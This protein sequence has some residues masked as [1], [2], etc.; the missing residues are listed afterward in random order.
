MDQ[1]VN[2]MH[3]ARAG[4]RARWFALAWSACVVVSALPSDAAPPAGSPIDNVARADGRDP[5]SG[6]ALWADSNPVR[7]VVQPLEALL[8]DPGRT[9]RL[10]AGATARM[11]HRLLNFSNA[12]IEVRLLLDNRTGDDFDLSGL[13]LIHDRDRDG[14]ATAADAAIPA[15]GTVVLA[16][17]DSA[18]LLIEATLPPVAT[19]GARGLLSLTAATLLQGATA[20]GLDTVVVLPAD[21][22]TAVLFTEMS[23]S[24]SS[25][26]IGDAV[27]YTVRV[28]NTSDST[29]AAVVLVEQ[30]SR[31]ISY[32]P[33]TARR[34]DGTALP[35]PRGGRGP[36]LEFDLGSLGP[37][38]LATVRLRA[39]VSPGARDG[40]GI[41]RA[42]ATGIRVTSNVATA[43][44]SLEPGVFA[45]E[46]A[47]MG[48][49]FVDRDGDRRRGAG[50]VGM[51]GIRVVV[52]DG[53][54]AVTDDEGRYS[55]Y[56]LSPRTHGLRPDPATFPEHVRQVGSDHRHG[57]GSTVRFVDVQ[58]GDLQRADFVLA[59]TPEPGSSPR[60]SVAADSTVRM[61]AQA[62][63]RTWSGAPDELDRSLRRELAAQAAAQVEGDPRA[64][65]TTGVSEGGSLLAGLEGGGYAS[66]G[67]RA[68]STKDE[69]A[70]SAAPPA[71]GPTGPSAP[72]LPLERRLDGL[73]ASV[74]FVDWADGDTASTRQVRVVAKGVAGVQFELSVDGAPVAASRVG[75]RV[76]LHD[77]G[78]EAVEYVGV[79]LA[80]GVNRLTIAQRDRLG[81]ERGRVA[82]EVVAPDRL[83][84]LTLSAP[85]SAPTGG[86]GE[87]AVMVRAT[88]ARGVP[89]PERVFVTLETSHGHWRADDLDPTAAGMQVA[90]EGG[91][92]T[93]SL[94]A[95]S[96]PGTARLVATASTPEGTLRAERSL[97]FLPGLR[98]LLMVGTIEGTMLLRNVG[99]GP[100]FA[101]AT[102]GF[103]QSTSTL[104]AR[105]DAA[106][107]AH[108]ALFVKGRVREDVM[109]TVGF[110]SDR[111]SDTRRFRDIQPDAYYPV[112]GD[113]AV[114][115]YEAQSSGRLYA[116]VDRLGASLLY[117]DFV[118]AGAGG[119]RTLSAYSRSLTGVQQ[120]Y[121]SARWRLESFGSN[122]R[123]RRRL[124]ELPGRGV[125]GPYQ[126]T[127][128][129]IVENSEVVERIVRDRNQP[130]VV[131]GVEALTRFTDY[132]LEPLTGRLLFTAPVPSFDSELNPVSLRVSYDTED[133]GASY[134]VSGAEGR[135]K[136]DERIELGGSLV[137]DRDPARPWNLRSAFAAARLGAG[138][139]LEA[140]FARSEAEGESPGDGGRIELRHDG[141]RS[142]GRLFAAL[143]DSSFDNPGA[144]FG[145]GRGEAGARWSV[146]V[147]ERTRA[148]AEGTFTA[149]AEGRERRG[150]M[151]LALDQGITSSLRG[152][153]GVR[154]SG[155]T[156][157]TG[158]DERTSLALRTKLLAQW[159][160]RPELTGYTEFEQDAREDSRRLLA[161]GGEY[162]FSGR[163]RFY[164]RHELLSSLSNVYALR[165]GE[166]RLATVLGF[167]ADVARDAHA[168]SEYRL[169][170]ALAGR[171]AEAAVGLRNTW[172]FDEWRVNTSF[173]RVS[174]LLGSNAGP[175]TAVTG[176]IETTPDPGTRASARVELRTSRANDSFLSTLG[177]ATRMNEAWTL[178][179]RTVTTLDN[180]RS[181]GVQ[182]RVRLQ[183]GAAYRDP[184]RDRWDGL[185]R[186]ELHVD[187]ESETPDARRRRLA[188]V[189]SVH[190]TGRTFELVRTTLSWAGK[191]ARERADG[192]TTTSDAQRLQLRLSRDVAKH[193]DVG[194]QT[195]ALWSD[196]FRTRRDGLGGEVGRMLQRDVWLSAG[197]NRF[198]YTDAD[199]PAD[200]WTE[201]GVY[202]RL[203]AK[204]DESVFGRL[205]SA[206]P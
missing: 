77:R 69:R 189:V 167:D 180:Q 165:A 42:W 108:A 48:V 113:A 149:E 146:R 51:P 190:A 63:G 197:W 65:P 153:F 174:P 145:A 8:V 92:A 80:P 147:N 89:V 10:A 94:G 19:A 137:D 86:A 100:V 206:L 44:V 120:R 173:E 75:R 164:A 114:R 16:A 163:G 7:T 171:E 12:G 132:T 17:G 23:V 115:G 3:R 126:L 188:N 83:A 105:L 95:P 30:L 181:R 20:A 60:D 39:R 97:A 21:D 198:G 50:D 104:G 196:G 82:I 142:Q 151:L 59:V 162:R 159:P 96:E 76:T 35:E 166:R 24:R 168:F 93:V 53:T 49:V 117:G 84:R 109:L 6:A 193:W 148:L 33:G 87:T 177:L 101:P 112:Y 71:G 187:R 5:L 127:G 125:S 27:D 11:R 31:G 128:L 28:T 32:V 133:G 14:Q 182:A 156:S 9:H 29:A 178:L 183:I 13:T 38:E 57:E 205:G 118:T 139:T 81:V 130:S 204:F 124:E 37:R 138:T 103:E 46:G 150:G 160:S 119:I 34:V 85:A 1:P 43:R 200:G 154:V 36:R 74:G 201:E 52:D 121:E 56:G 67:V 143:T 2:G 61:I 122:A 144:G 22:G 152:E 79:P 161:F 172:R 54:F 169:A 136:V 41:S 192:L 68:S 140:E 72:E 141:A 129:P 58:R 55:L 175:A 194:L 26:E 116:R 64:R 66:Q 47:V 99:R 123:A 199:L 203:R 111:P 91:A 195:G 98:P 155:G 45:D 158:A 176:A 62:R 15:S 70:E 131:R 106:T 135:M 184:V 170:D 157:T 40:D 78:I 102:T 25:V 179:G 186:Y 191:V 185:A 202:L 107:G 88:D 4:G 110:D 73:D 134:W 18:D 90:V